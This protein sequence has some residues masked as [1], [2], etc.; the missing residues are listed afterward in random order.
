MNALVGILVFVVQKLATAL[1]QLFVV[2]TLVFSIMYIMPGDPVLLLLGSESSP[3]PETI[4]NMRARL[5][6]DQPVMTQ[7]VTWLT[8]IVHF[9]LGTS[10][11]GGYSVGQVVADNLPRTLE[12][13]LAAI[14]IA[15]LIGVPVGIAA[16]LNRGTLVDTA[17]T[18]MT[19]I[20]I[21]VPVYILGALLIILFSLQLG[22]LPSSG[23]MDIGRNAPEH[24][25]RLVLPAFTLGFGLAASIARMTRSSM[26]EILNRD[27]IRALRAKGMSER[28]IIWQHALRNA[29][30]PVVT[31]IGLQLG[32]LM[33]GTVLVE[34]MFN[35]PGLSTLL[36]DAVSSRDYPV[37]QGSVLA[38]AALF[39]FINLAVELIYGL[40]DPRIRRRRT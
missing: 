37:V 34:A 33:G 15:S 16:A 17:L 12:L 21:S 40:L 5:G 38:I 31:I 30:I 2:A 32:N 14:V 35:W 39:I 28:R 23:Y 24:F 11:L 10:I 6:L 25:R 19:T 27:F 22:W 3:S 8:N 4:A 36:V 9:D 13:G 29:S 18:S 20:G 1:A 26:L 7:Y